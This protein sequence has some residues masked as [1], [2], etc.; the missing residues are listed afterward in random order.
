MDKNLRKRLTNE[1][2]DGESQ[3]N[4]FWEDFQNCEKIYSNLKN[5][6]RFSGSMLRLARGPPWKAC[7]FRCGHSALS[8]KSGPGNNNRSDGPPE[9]GFLAAWKACKG[10]ERRQLV[11][12]SI[13]GAALNLGFGVVIPALPVL[14]QELGFGATGV[15]L[16]LAAP[17]LARV[18]FNLPA[19]A[20]VDSFGRVPCMIAGE[21]FAALGCLGT[22]LALSLNTMLP[23]RFMGGTGA[24]LAAAGSAAYLADLT[25]RP[26]LKL[27]C[28][29]VSV[30][31]FF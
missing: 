16:L 3:N 19:G 21:M 14:S 11:V 29:C 4:I 9:P 17:S 26:H 2:K 5:T 15:G 28:A 22:G 24:A 8:T 1:M 23:V 7:T 30:W 27:D 12:L 13:S 18:M 31:L 20:L 25:E 10:E 6:K